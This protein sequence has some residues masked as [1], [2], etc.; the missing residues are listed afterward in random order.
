MAPISWNDPFTGF[1]RVLKSLN[2]TSTIKALKG[3][4]SEQKVLN[5]KSH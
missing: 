2:L 3:L 1:L 5:S 4:E